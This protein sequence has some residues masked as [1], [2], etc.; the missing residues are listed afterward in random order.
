M[1]MKKIL[2]H[3]GTLVMEDKVVKADLLIEGEKIAGILA[4]GETGIDAERIDASDLFVMPGTIDPHV[5]YGLHNPVGE[6]FRNDTPVQAIGGM[7][8]IVN[9]HRGN[10]DYFES[11]ADWR[12]Q[13]EENSLIDFAFTL[14]LC[15]KWD[16]ENLE[17]FVDE[18]GITSFK[19]FFDKQDIADKFYHLPR[20]DM[21]TLDKADLYFLLKKLREIN[22]KLLMCIHCE[23]RD[24]FKA[25]EEYVQNSDMDQYA[26]ETFHA[27]RPDFVES[28]C[29]ANAIL[30]SG[31]TKG[32]IY[33]VHTSSKAS[34]EVYCALKHLGGSV[35]LETCPHYLLLDEHTPFGL[36]AKVNPPIRTQMDAEALWQGIRDGSIHS[37]GTDNA[38]SYRSERYEKGRDF[39]SALT[40]FASNGL[41]LPTLISEGYLKR[42]ISLPRLSQVNSIHTARKFCLKGKG[43]L[44][45]G[46][47]ADLALIDLN[48]ERTVGPELFGNADYSIFEG[49]TF[50]GWPKYTISRGEI[51]QKDG[52]ITAQP[53][54]GR[55]LFRKL[56]E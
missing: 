52:S 54:R 28:I 4:P 38:M 51:I 44:V 49:M 24:L 29:V 14:G 47:D 12:R 13:G 32:N 39:M 21:L 45:V 19:F 16:V 50:R 10:M 15:K 25:L 36:D 7:T 8:T 27:T 31:V 37:M 23:D 11:I 53:G 3:D 30:L 35:T 6:D 5:H 9:Y 17:R 22:P 34:L 42:G 20:E 48:I 26:L 41:V 40:G 18:L 2:I 33:I 1:Q 46:F 43:E 56:D 55:Y